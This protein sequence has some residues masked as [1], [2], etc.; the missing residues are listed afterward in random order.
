MRNQQEKDNWR[1]II[2][3]YEK[4]SVGK[5]VWQLIN[6][7]VPFLVLWYAAYWSLSV[8]YWLTLGFSI[9][10][11]GLMVRIFI[12][13]HDCCHGSFFANRKANEIIGTIAGIFTLTPYHQW[14]YSHTRHHATSGNL[15]H[16][17][18]GDIWTLTVEEYLALPRW[19]RIA[20]R[21]YRNPLVLFGLGPIYLFLIDNRFNRKGAKKRERF[22]TY[23]VNV[24]IVAIISL[25]C[26]LIGWKAFLLVQGPIFLL[27]SLAGVWLF[28]V[29]HQFEGAYFEKEEN[30]NFVDAALQGSS[31]YNLPR[32]LHWFTGNI[33][34]H[35]IHHLSARVPNYHLNRAHK[36]NRLFQEVN[37]ISLWSSLRSL[38]YRIWDENRKKLVGFQYVKDFLRAKKQENKL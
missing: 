18:E 3:P 23:L 22:N 21:L 13:F 36:E 4:P 19:K 25:L 27:S 16:H 26:W 38:S 15:D 11:A 6:T 29:Q 31:F 35:H 1:K 12:I 14:R 37:S 7:F 17:G 24:S 2:S 32:L 34:Y 8:S 30:W 9:V 28:Y 10:A 33:G 5:S 20:Y